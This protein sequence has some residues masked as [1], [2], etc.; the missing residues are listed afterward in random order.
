MDEKV[1]KHSAPAFLEKL[2]DILEDPELEPYIGSCFEPKIKCKILFSFS[3]FNLKIFFAPHSRII[4]CSMA[5]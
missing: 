3:H 4:L 1:A 2:F 5:T